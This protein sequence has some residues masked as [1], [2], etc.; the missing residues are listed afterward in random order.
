[1]AE[2]DID[3]EKKNSQVVEYLQGPR[4]KRKNYILMAVRPNFDPDLLAAIN[5][6]VKKNFSQFA[7]VQPKG[8]DE[9][10]RLFSRQIVLTM[11]D[12]S[13]IELDDLLFVLKE[14]KIKK[15]G[16]ASP[17]LFFTENI[18]RLINAYH[19]V[20]LPFQEMDNYLSYRTMQRAQIFA[21]IQNSLTKKNG[22][23]ARRYK[24]NIN[25]NYFNL[26]RDKYFNGKIIELSSQ[27]GLLHCLEEEIF[28]QGDQL[29]LHIPLMGY[30]PLDVGEF[31]RVSGRVRRVLMGGTKAAISWEYLGEDQFI[32]LTDFILEYVNQ[33]S[34]RNL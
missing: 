34:R 26:R 13:F 30:L 18:A 5:Q 7:L 14:M 28:N 2:T 33:Q 8:K 24:F 20:L 9:L 16:L 19:K 23:N 29:K 4:R 27:G 22:R 25:V 32:R 10:V 12:D 21:R 3:E 15:S 1:M 6:F 17:V 11:V 31:I